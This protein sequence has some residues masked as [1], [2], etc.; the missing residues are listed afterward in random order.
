MCRVPRINHID[1]PGLIILYK[2]FSIIMLSVDLARGV[3]TLP[4]SVHLDAPSEPWQLSLL[5]TTVS[6][7]DRGRNTASCPSEVLT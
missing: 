7:K 2:V 5:I 4:V 6:V 1:S 3:F